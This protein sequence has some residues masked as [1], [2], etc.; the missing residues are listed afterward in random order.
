VTSK[1]KMFA[2][3]TVLVRDFCHVNGLPTPRIVVVPK[4]EWRFGGTCAYY[5]EDVITIC[6]ERCA[7]VGHG[8]PAWSYPGYVADRTPYGVMAHE[9]GHHVDYHRSQDKGAYGGDFSV[10]MRRAS[11]EKRLTSYCPNDWEWFAEMFRLFC[12]NSHLLQCIRP[13]TYDEMVGE[14]LKPVEQRGWGEVL[15]DA[16]ERTREMARKKVMHGHP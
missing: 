6:L 2:G 1:L 4:G 3:G 5:R 14:G 7:H 15:K 11:G 9:L 8:G 13:R 10:A 12:T 16:P